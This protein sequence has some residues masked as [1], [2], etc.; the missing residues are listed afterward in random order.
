MQSQLERAKENIDLRLQI[1]KLETE[2]LALDENA[3]LFCEGKLS[4]ED[5]NPY[6]KDKMVMMDQG[7]GYYKDL[8]IMDLLG[9]IR[10]TTMV[11]AQDI[12]LSSRAYLKASQDTLKTVTSDALIA[13]S[14]GSLIVNTVSPIFNRDGEVM[15]YAGIAIKAAYFS[16]IV[17]DLKLGDEGYYGIV[18]SNYRILAHPNADLIYKEFPYEISMLLKRSMGNAVYNGPSIFNEKEN[19]FQSYKYIESNKWYLVATLPERELYSQS[20]LL[21]SYVIIA[22]SMGILVAIGIGYYMG[23]QIT[24]PIIAITETLE[25]LTSSRQLIDTAVGASI[26]HMEAIDLGHLDRNNGHEPSVGLYKKQ[27]IRSTGEDEIGNLRS[28]I[29]ALREYLSSMSGF[30]EKESEKL[31]R[32]SRQV[33]QSINSMSF[34]T[35]KF[36]ATLS[37]DLKTSITLIKGYA[38]GLNTGIIKDEETKAKFLNG[39]LSSAEDIESITCDIL[40]HAYEAQCVPKL[41]K[42]WVSVKL[43][44]EAL[45]SSTETYL[46]EKNRRFI[47]HIDEFEDEL[48][49]IDVVKIKRVWQNLI[50]N[51]VKYSKDETLIECAIE[52]DLENKRIQLGVHDQGVGIEEAHLSNLQEMFYRAERDETKG[53]GLGLFIARSILEA[54]ASR[55]EISSV[56]GEGTTVCFCL[57]LCDNLEGGIDEA[58]TKC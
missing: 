42:E 10:G 37:H 41:K 52:Y 28:A 26:T 45:L 34:N 35:A 20:I 22:G 13:R 8:F 29:Y 1:T 14:D 17:S 23:N 31:M 49:N 46:L 36:I 18:D 7:E 39:I 16:K 44:S 3:L 55:L 9:I 30:F 5:I 6:L 47:H 11:E 58:E 15:G 32:E 33:T 24:K 57:Q 12:D 43:F 51:A 50:S 19:A 40:D 25:N 27:T 48:L 21:L 53:Y 56:W 38:R 54:H 2:K 4:V